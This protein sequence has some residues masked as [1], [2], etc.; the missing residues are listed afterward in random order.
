MATSESLLQQLSEIQN[1][2]FG[3]EKQPSKALPQKI[4]KKEHRQPLLFIDVNLG[5]ARSERIVVREGDTPQS[6]AKQFTIRHN[7][8]DGLQG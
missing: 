4:K 1:L 7:L 2:N 5:P 8:D 6:V 3:Q